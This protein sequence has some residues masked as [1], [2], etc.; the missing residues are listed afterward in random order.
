MHSREF[1]FFFFTLRMKPEKLQKSKTVDS[2]FSFPFFSFTAGDQDVSN[3]GRNSPGSGRGLGGHP[4]ERGTNCA[5][6]KMIRNLPKTTVCMYNTRVW[7]RVRQIPILATAR[8]D[9]NDIHLLS[10]TLFRL[11]LNDCDFRTHPQFCHNGSSVID[12][13]F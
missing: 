4:Q 9:L 3:G 2:F 12:L 11:Q 7:S 10:S 5:I 6:Y 13:P 1:F 8:N